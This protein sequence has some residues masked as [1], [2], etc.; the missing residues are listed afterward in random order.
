MFVRHGQVMEVCGKCGAVVP[1]SECELV[2]VKTGFVRVEYD[3]REKTPTWDKRRKVGGKF[4]AE[5]VMRTAG[6]AATKKV[7]ACKACR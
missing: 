3:S 2:L 4:G 1:A 6:F 7:H 5:P